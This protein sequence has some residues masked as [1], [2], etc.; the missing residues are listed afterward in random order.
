[1]EWPVAGAAAIF[2]RHLCGR[3]LPRSFQARVTNGR[4]AIEPQRSQRQFG[5][6][7][8]LII[9]EGEVVRVDCTGWGKS[10]R[11]RYVIFA[12]GALVVYDGPAL[13][14][15]RSE[16]V[17][18]TAIIRS[19]GYGNA[20]QLETVVDDVMDVVVIQKPSDSYK[21]PPPVSGL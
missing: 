8:E 16:V 4:D 7:G 14:V 11:G 1:M 9:V 10:K 3:L 12:A 20:D 19:H 2:F 13:L 18:F 17:R 21:K 5:S 15:D 6:I